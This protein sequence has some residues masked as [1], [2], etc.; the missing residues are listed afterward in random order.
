MRRSHWGFGALLG[1]ITSLPLIALS[2]LGQQFAGLPFLPFDLFDWLARRLPGGVISLGIDAI[3]RTITALRLGPI[4]GSAKLIE[5]AIALALV[6]MIGAALGL[7]VA[8][9]LRLGAGPG[10]RA[11]S[12]GGFAL[13]VLAAAMAYDLGFAGDPGLPLA[14]LAILLMG[15][16]TLLGGGLSAAVSQPSLDTA[17]EQ[18]VTRRAVF[19]L[20][21]G[22][23]GVA[24]TA[25]GAARLFQQARVATGA[26][27]PLALA[28]AP[29]TSFAPPSAQVLAERPAPAP[30]T[31]PELT[32]TERFYR[33]DVDTRPPVIAGAAWSLQVAGLFAH[34]RPL[35]LADLRAY[36]AVAQP[37]TVSCISNPIGGDLIGT[38]NWVGARLRDVLADLGLMPGA[39]QITITAADG[40]YES[41]TMAD[42]LDPRTLLVYGMNGATLP[43]EH[44]FPLRIYIPNHYGMKQPKWI[45]RIEA[46]D[47]PGPGY[48]V[49]R[50]WSAEARP[51]VISI[52]DSVTRAGGADGLIS[53]GGIAWAGDRG[54]ERVELQI[55]D[56]PWSTAV[57]RQPPLSPLTWVQWRLDMPLAPGRHTFRV[58]ATDGTGAAQAGGAAPPAPS[59]ATGYHTTTLTL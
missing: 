59:G 53:A 27:Q 41:V 35:T 40:F 8:L 12:I 18:V 56:Q 49:E 26:S 15:W 34:P 42:M 31:R 50:G 30:G 33:I 9:L 24:I 44:G 38:A 54:I 29:G 46:I 5:Q 23:V 21:G 43:I 2:F 20:A 57:L 7:L 48:W 16:G 28:Q 58:R 51:Q 55:D 19:R 47:H 22:S 3:V 1:A 6:V 39:Q 25:W 14:W 4:S 11:G 17:P 45:T 52:I 13:F 32:P 36:P 37:S 10:W